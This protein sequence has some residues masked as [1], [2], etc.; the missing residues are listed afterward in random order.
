MASAHVRVRTI[1]NDIRRGKIKFFGKEVFSGERFIIK[2]L[3]YTSYM[4][5]ISVP[6]PMLKVNYFLEIFFLQ[7]GVLDWDSHIVARAKNFLVNRSPEKS[8]QPKKFEF[9]TNVVRFYRSSAS[10]HSGHT[11]RP[12]IS[13]W[14]MFKVVDRDWLMNVRCRYGLRKRG[15]MSYC[16]RFANSP[17]RGICHICHIANPRESRMAS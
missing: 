4:K 5:A 14:M 15:E 9:S 10:M 7:H 1:K 12:F 3:I 8:S 2:G 17:Y 11:I 6:N 16:A 13:T